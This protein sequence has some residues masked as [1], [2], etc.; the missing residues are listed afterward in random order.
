ML[1]N[2]VFCRGRPAEK[3]AP[4]A[5]AK[6]AQETLMLTLAREIRGTGVTA[7]VLQVREIDVQPERTPKKPSRTTPEEITAAI[8]YLCSEQAQTVNGARI[9]LYGAA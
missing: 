4:Y 6:A 2:W 5:I 8:L 3:S 7:N 1:A 9:P